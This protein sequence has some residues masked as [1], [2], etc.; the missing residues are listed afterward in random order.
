MHNMYGE[1]QNIAACI[2]VQVRM[3]ARSGSRMVV[4]DLWPLYPVKGCD[5]RTHAVSTFQIQR[6]SARHERALST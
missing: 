3:S 2:C 5:R 4:A 6:P 1:N